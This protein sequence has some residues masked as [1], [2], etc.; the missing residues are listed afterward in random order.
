MSF[1]RRELLYRSALVPVALSPIALLQGCADEAIATCAD[2]ETLTRGEAHM[3]KTLEYS[4][5]SGDD[6]QTC[7]TCQFFRAASGSACG[8]CEILSGPVDTAGYCTSWALKK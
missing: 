1:S 3:R 2:P 8:E 7:A 4:V 6:S 5:V